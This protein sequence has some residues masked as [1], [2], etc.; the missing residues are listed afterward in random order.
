MTDYDKQLNLRK[1]HPLGRVHLRINAL[2]SG[3]TRLTLK[4][5]LDL[6]YG[7]T[8]GQ[9]IDLFPARHSRAPVFVFIHGGYFRALDK[10]QY[11]Y[12]AKPFVAG[13]CTVALINYDLAPAVSVQDIIDQNIKAF[14]WIHENIRRWNGNPEHMVLCGH[15]VGAF[16]VAKILEFNGARPTRQAIKGVALLSGLYDLTSMKQSYLN[17]SLG[18]TDD[19]V[20]NLSPIFGDVSQFPH[21]LVAVGEHETAEFIEQSK[22][23]SRKL[24]DARRSH[25]YLLLKGKNH[26]T[27]SRLLSK[28]S[29]RLTQRIL[30]MCRVDSR[31][32]SGSPTNSMG[33]KD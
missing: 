2:Q 6:R 31:V 1:R 23:Y 28:G 27:V 11:S 19:D 8:P 22:N 5:S 30:D 4:T 9:R 10:S 15:S 32:S 21:A 3:F 17:Q 25:E 18:L 7:S 16:L 26:Y 12:M 24:K 14:L 13:G 33:S 29:N 20:A